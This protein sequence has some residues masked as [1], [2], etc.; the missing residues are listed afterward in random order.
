MIG[1][2]D[3]VFV[4]TIA[5]VSKMMV[6]SSD[7][8][9]LSAALPVEQGNPADDPRMFRRCLSQYGTGVAILTTADGTDRSAVTVNSFSSLSLDPP[10]LLWSIDKRSRSFPA[11]STCKYFAVNILSSEQIELSRHFSSKLVDK[12][13]SVDWAAG[14]FES[15]LLAGCIAHFECSV[16]ARHDGGDHLILIGHVKQ[17]ARFE[18]VPLIFSQGQYS[19]PCEHPDVPAEP[20]AIADASPDAPSNNVLQLIFN[21]HHSL[22]EAF[23][24]HRRAEGVSVAVARVLASVCSYPGIKVDG[25]ASQTYLGQRDVEDAVSELERKS[26]LTRADNGGMQLT[27]A[28]LALRESIR[29]R[30]IAFQDAQ[31]EGIPSPEIAVVMRTLTR[32]IGR[33]RKQEG[34]ATAAAVAGG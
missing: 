26:L 1:E 8:Q 34:T 30:W 17:L 3:F 11:F 31:L 19:I 16:D 23:E 12:F 25:I 32:M 21:A 10:L 7:Q 24:E 18:G 27:K 28:G 15:P 2:G 6:P 5:R 29:E 22:S 33:T 4:K 9:A 20:E 14:R 13:E